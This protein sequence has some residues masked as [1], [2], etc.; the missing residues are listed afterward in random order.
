MRF[1]L[2]A[3]YPDS[4]L[5]FRG[6]LL[7]NL[8]EAGYEV[9]IAAPGLLTENVLRVEMEKRGFHVHNVPLQRTGMNPV[10]DF[11]T[12]I[13]YFCLLYK[14]RPSII[15]AYTIK[16]VIYG[17]FIGTI[18]GIPK[19]FA[20]ITGLGFTFGQTGSVLSNLSKSI[21]RKLYT[22]SLRGANKVFFQNTDDRK[23][24]C[25]LNILKKE[26]PSFVLNG[27]GVD[28]GK[29]QP[30]PLP[31]C[32]VF[33]M[34]ARLLGAKGVREY[35]HAAQEVK[36]RYPLVEFT[37]VGWV[38]DNP[39]SISQAELDSWIDEGTIQFKGYMTDVRSA[40]ADCSVFVLP[41]YREGV[42]RTVLEAMAMGRAIIT[43]NVP[44][45]RE[46]VLDDYNG[47]LVPAQSASSLV[48]AMVA[49]V[50][51]QNKSRRMG[52]NSRILAVEKFDVHCVNGNMLVEMGIA[53][54]A[55]LADYK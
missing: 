20:L 41:S 30:A 32:T 13:A 49:F 34:I 19:R 47:Y 6:E 51:D 4:I 1:L 5:N 45:C 48:K 2:L 53:R 9:H 8:A 44:G 39:D 36:K 25:E 28:L 52:E 46:T 17:I 24:F 10:G 3:S 50:E 55:G 22:V 15:L 43:T 42:P 16:P 35:V 26:V 21:A 27:S 40:I 33:L 14:L 23:L 38:D 29:Y 18:L 54:S 37:L 11:R 12:L 7:A 31:S